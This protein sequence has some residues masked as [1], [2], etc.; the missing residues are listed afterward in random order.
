[1]AAAAA[2]AAAADSRKIYDASIDSCRSRRR[3]S[4]LLG[5]KSGF[6]VNVLIH[7]ARPTKCFVGAVGPWLFID[8]FIQAAF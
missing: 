6:S 1:V 5:A 8:V 4:K 2:A 7:V 3:H